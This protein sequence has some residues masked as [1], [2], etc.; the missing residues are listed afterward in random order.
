LA[1][2]R[3]DIGELEH[4]E[5][6]EDRAVFRPTGQFSVEQAVEL[7]RAAIEFARARHI[8]KLLVDASNLTVFEP[9]SIA[10]RYFFVHD[11]AR[12]AAGR[13]RVAF[14]ARPEMIDPQKFGHTVAANVGFITDVFTTEEDAQIWLQA[15]S[16]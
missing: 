10:R 1:K 5:M 8:R 15:S 12:A 13:V 11:W 7:V 6:L 14:L 4:F 3:V 9:P 2:D 16:T